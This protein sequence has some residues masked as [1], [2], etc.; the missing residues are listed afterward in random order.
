MT[1][2][3]LD[4][5]V[6]GGTDF[7]VA[8]EHAIKLAKKLDLAYVKFHFNNIACSIGQNTSI[9]EAMGKYRSCDLS[10][11]LQFITLP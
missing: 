7:S 11:K 1:P 6:L 2:L 5:G 10:T 8:V 4:I 9:A 3:T